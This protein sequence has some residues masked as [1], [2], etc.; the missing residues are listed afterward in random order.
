RPL[1]AIVDYDEAL[2]YARRGAPGDRDRGLPLVVA[3]LGKFRRL[4][5][6]GWIRRA[7]TLQASCE[8]PSVAPPPAAVPL[9]APAAPIAA[10]AALHCEG[11]YWTLA[12]G[13]GVSRVRE[14][15]GLRYLVHLLRHPGQEVHV[16][17]LIGQAST[18]G[19]AEPNR[20][21]AAG[22]LP[23]LDDRAKA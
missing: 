12:Y 20:P 13:G 19:S 4:G 1:R 11:D 16:L 14:M 18:G 2:M 21:L 23:R 9:P 15:K 3:A 17:D 7:E 5:M 6:P 10:Q 8:I 22:A